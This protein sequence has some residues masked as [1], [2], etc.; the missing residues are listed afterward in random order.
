LQTASNEYGVILMK[1]KI[2]AVLMGGVSN[3]REISLK[4][5]TAIY[6][7]LIRKGYNAKT[8]DIN[9]KN[10]KLFINDKFDIAFI[11]LHG[12]YGEDGIVQAI[13][14]FSDIPYT[15]SGVTASALAMD[16]IL[17]K[18]IFQNINVPTARFWTL[19]EIEKIEFPLV[20]KPTAEG[21]T[22]GVFIVNNKDNFQYYLKETQ[23]ISEN[24]FFEEYISGREVTVSVLNGKAL[25]VIEI[26]PKKGFYDYESKYQK[27][28]TEYIVPAD[29]PEEI[30][31]KLKEYSEKIFKV[32]NLKGAVRVDYIVKNNVCYALEV[33]TIP[34]MTET[35]LL[36]KA[37]K[38]IGIDFDT[39]VEKILLSTL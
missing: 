25:P 26:K 12:T 24:I 30:N 6:H 1:N 3:E 8:I 10:L 35:S 17:S 7:A 14:E 28:M 18:R 11:A 36:P 27:G 13:L 37:A 29:L 16:K 2:I 20:I 32:F 33:N 4:T 5:G 38:V 39:L 15:G 19:D 34:G 21:S 31:N 9:E 23:K 22:V